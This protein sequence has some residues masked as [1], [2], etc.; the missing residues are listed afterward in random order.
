MLRL[1]LDYLLEK[2]NQN[3]S[4]GE[5]R[6]F[7]NYFLIGAKSSDCFSLVLARVKVA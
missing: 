1:T 6:F 7:P 3:F 2:S 5:C 4:V